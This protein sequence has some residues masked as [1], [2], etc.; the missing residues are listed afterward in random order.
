[1]AEKFGELIYQDGYVTATMER[2]VEAPVD[3]VWDF[4]A[5][6]GKRVLWLAPGTIELRQGG[7]AELDFKD[8]YVIVDSEVTAC[9]APGLLEFSWSGKDEPLRPVRFELE[10]SDNGCL[11][12]L[13]VSIP[14]NEVVPRSCAG[15]EAHLTML[16][17]AVAEVPIKF[18]LERFN[19]CREAFEKELSRVMM[20][21]VNVLKL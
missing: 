4:L 3:R 12:R 9:V 17:A 14:E 8:S 6:E 2:A 18:P 19:E 21:A 1:M 16:Q 10:D 20:D 15:W 5:E 7:R 11:I 13:R